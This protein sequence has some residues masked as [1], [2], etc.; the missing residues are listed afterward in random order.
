M[1]FQ[2]GIFANAQS[3]ENPKK[4][5]KKERKELRLKEAKENKA[6]LME[7]INNKASVLET[8]IKMGSN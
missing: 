2:I 3:D 4:L 6:K 7:I 5:S 8:L 1:L